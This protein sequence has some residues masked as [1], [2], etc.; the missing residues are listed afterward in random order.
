MPRRM[1]PLARS[2]KKASGESAVSNT[3]GW[4][5]TGRD[6]IK[7]K[8]NSGG[9]NFAPMVP[10]FFLTDSES[11]VLK[12]VEPFGDL[13]RAVG[14]HSYPATSKA[15]K[16]YFKSFTCTGD[17]DTCVG[18]ARGDK[19]SMRWP[20][21]V[22]DTREMQYQEYDPKTK[23]KKKV[24][25]SNVVKVWKPS[26]NELD[27]F[28][29]AVEDYED[30]TRKS[31]KDTSRLVVRVRRTGQKAQ[32]AYSFTVKKAVKLSEAD[33]KK[34]DIFFEEFGPIEEILKPIP[35]AEQ[36][37]IAGAAVKDDEEYGDDDDEEDDVL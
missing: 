5:T 24:T 29:G 8:A 35:L 16:R 34:V 33:Q 7:E 32:T 25:K 20:L 17:P 37:V 1:S 14:Q 28:F 22:I 23:T 15:G 30:D 21:I 19:P 3:P 10:E 2:A 4:M 13:E 9:G 12:L 31:V 26:I 11:A 27:R 36:K 6:N 18:C